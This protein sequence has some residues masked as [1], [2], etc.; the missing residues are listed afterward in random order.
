MMSRPLRKD[1]HELIRL[2]RYVQ[3]YLED[4]SI[5]TGKLELEMLIQRLESEE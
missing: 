5:G 3:E 1:K 4:G 2:L